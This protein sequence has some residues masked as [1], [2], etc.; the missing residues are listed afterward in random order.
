[1]MEDYAGNPKTLPA[2]INRDIEKDKADGKK[3]FSWTAV[4]AWSQFHNPSYPNNPDELAAGVSPVK[5]TTEKLSNDINVVS[6]EEL[7]WRLR[8][9]HNPK[10]TK[11]VIKYWK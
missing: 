7:I 3:S 4:H 6:I 8:M 2:K 10:E 9:E 5:W 11:T 1:M